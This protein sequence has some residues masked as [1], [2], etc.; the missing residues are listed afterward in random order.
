VEALR[1]A[2]DRRVIARHH[3]AVGRVVPPPRDR[4][5]GR[6]DCAADRLSADPAE[7]HSV[8]HQ[9]IDLTVELDAPERVPPQVH[10][11]RRRRTAS[12]DD[13]GVSR[14]E[15]VTVGDEVAMRNASSDETGAIETPSA[16]RRRSPAERDKFTP[17]AG[18]G[19]VADRPQLG[20]ERDA[21][22][23][24]LYV[25]GALAATSVFVAKW[26]AGGPLTV[27]ASLA[28][29][30]VAN[31][32]PGAVADVRAFDVAIT[33]EAVATLFDGTAPTT[34]PPPMPDGDAVAQFVKARNE[35]CR[36]GNV[37]AGAIYEGEET[38][39]REQQVEMHRRRVVLGQAV[40][41]QLDAMEVPAELES[42]V[43]A[44]NASRASGLVAL[45][46]L[47]DALEAGDTGRLP[48]IEAELLDIAIETE[49]REDSLGL[50]HCP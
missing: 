37:E 23:L 39:S 44:D 18:D 50:V 48:Q 24:R 31:Y 42:F 20:V 45:A 22:G 25:D 21:G 12:S 40:Q 41:E 49:G 13:Q 9:R 32:W 27:G 11:H 1:L 33:D 29:G 6:H 36:G 26:Q 3:G 43:D 14:G 16:D 46:Q 7:A 35:I 34:P 5:G 15:V 47:A 4:S 10:V 30:Y 28:R 2:T 19:H 17:V 38:A 8:G